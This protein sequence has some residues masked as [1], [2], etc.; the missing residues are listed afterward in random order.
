MIRISAPR[1]FG[2]TTL[3]PAIFDFVGK[4]PMVSLDYRL[5][6]RYVDLV[7]EGIDSLSLN[8]D[9]V[10]GTWLMLAGEKRA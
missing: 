8:P 1:N 9:S 2:E 3:A 7:D 5:E 4:N 6:E 10:L